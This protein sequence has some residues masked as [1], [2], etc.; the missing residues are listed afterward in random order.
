MR[1]TAAVATLLL[2]ASAWA[3]PPPAIAKAAKDPARAE[4][5]KNDARRKGPE[6]LAFSGVK[7]GDTVLELIPGGGYFTRLFSKVVG[8]KGKVYAVWP[9]EYDKESHPD[10]DKMRAL[11]KEPGFG[12][13]E[14]I[15]QPAAQLAVPTPVDVVFTSQN[16][17]DYPDP[18]MGPTD[19]AVLN[20]AVFAALKPGGL[21]IVIDHV[22]EAGSG[23]RDTDTLHRIDPALVKKQVLA[24]GFE[25]VGESPLLKNPADDHKVKVFDPSVRGKTDQFT[26]KFRKPKQKKSH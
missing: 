1:W 10:S 17:H 5:A 9:S 15:V 6:L 23:V 11:A 12:N 16:Y 26:F 18:F 7:P 8:P 14:V 25:F 22:A 2:A 21:Y 4:D 19:P 20:K 3:A 24:A 13:L